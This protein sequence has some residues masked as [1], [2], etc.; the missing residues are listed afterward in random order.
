MKTATDL[1]DPQ[2]DASRVLTRYADRLLVVQYRDHHELLSLDDNGATWADNPG[3]L[4]DW[5]CEVAAGHAAAVAS[6]DVSATEIR[7][8]TGY[9]RRA[10]TRRGFERMLDAVGPAFL[11]MQES[12]DIPPC[13]TVVQAADLDHDPLYL[14]CANGVVDLNVGRLLPTEEG[15][16][17]LISRSTGVTFDPDAR[18]SSVDTLLALLSRPERCYL[19]DALGHALRGGTPRLWYL[20]CGEAGSGKST[21]VRTIAAALG[22]YACSLD[23]GLLVSGRHTNSLRFVYQLGDL[24]QAR[25]ALGD[26]WSGGG[27]RLNVPLIMELTGGGRLTSRT[28]YGYGMDVMEGVSGTIFHAM[29]PGDIDHLDF[30]D[31]ALV[32]RTHVMSCLPVDSLSTIEDGLASA[33][34]ADQAR[35]AMLA[36]LVQHAAENREPPD[37]PASV[38]RLLRERRRAS[39]GAVGR[40]LR[41]HLQV[42]GDGDEIV[43]ADEIM[44]ALAADIPPNDEGRFSGR[45]RREVLAL[46]RDLIDGFPTARRVKRGGRLVST[47]PGLRLLTTA[48]IDPA[49]AALPVDIEPRRA[50]A[51]GPPAAYTLGYCRACRIVMLEILQKPHLT[52]HT[53]EELRRQQHPCFRCETLLPA[54]DPFQL[55][56]TDCAGKTGGDLETKTAVMA[57][58][59]AEMD[60]PEGGMAGHLH[61]QVD[62]VHQV[63]Q[64]INA[65]KAEA[66]EEE[67]GGG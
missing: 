62:L 21:L 46:A 36:L 15:R 3:R 27:R 26:G 4:Q 30:S 67:N 6:S 34:L 32:D 63:L 40:W 53:E 61:A 47:Y 42:T 28:A 64:E 23:A 11:K 56:C 25:I 65:E 24:T 55:L 48:D 35:Q 22:G 10:R 1:L 41:D 58:I 50:V 16:R 39:I 57:A 38:T 59:A 43:L 66:E 17:K 13:M 2:G 31:P 9:L 60:E 14:G 51:A 7:A 37:A 44:E 33:L 20:L 19:L 29:G 52:Q 45:T 5:H 8:A 54:G 49:V 18:D 12:G